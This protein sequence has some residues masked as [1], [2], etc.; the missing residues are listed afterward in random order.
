MRSRQGL[1]IGYF[2]R[3]IKVRTIVH[4]CWILLKKSVCSRARATLKYST[5]RI[6][7]GSTIV[8][9]G[10]VWIPP[11]NYPKRPSKEFFNGICCLAVA[12]PV[13]ALNSSTPIRWTHKIGHECPLSA[14][15]RINYNRTDTDIRH[16]A[17]TFCLKCSRF[18]RYKG[19]F[20]TR[21]STSMQSVGARPSGEFC[22]A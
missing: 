18:C 1:Y 21:L 16:V 11:R 6:A 15:M 2:D 20:L 22:R 7:P 5:F 4:E 13:S 3:T 12:R 8:T 19:S 10:M 9:S 17:A 14:S